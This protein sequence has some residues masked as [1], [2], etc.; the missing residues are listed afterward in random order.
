MTWWN[1]LWRRRQMEEQLEKE[2]RFHVD[3]HAADLISRGY[4][5]AEARRQARLALGGPEQVKEECRDARGTRWLQDLWQDAAYALRTLRQKP[6]FATVSVLTLALGI[7]ASTAIFSAVNPI[8]FEPL[9]YPHASRI[10]MI[11]GTFRGGHSEVAFHTYRELAARSR[12]FEAIAVMK[13]WRP[14]MTGE[15][16]P[17]PFEGQRV[18]W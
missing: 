7:G 17:Q 9:P 3:Q 4:H 14:T 16:Q 6:G 15:S 8:L 1:R 11:S 10:L 2:V 5:P 18:S 13:P 12:A